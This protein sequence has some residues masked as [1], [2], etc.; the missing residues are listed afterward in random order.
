MLRTSDHHQKIMGWG[1][2][3][4]LYVTERGGGAW[5]NQGNDTL[6]GGGEGVAQAHLFGGPGDDTFFIDS[7]DGT[8]PFGDHVFGGLGA[9][10]F[11]FTGIIP[12]TARITGR[13]DDFDPTRDQ[14]WID[15]DLIDLSNPPDHVRI[16]LWLDQPWI[17]IDGRIL[18]ALEGARQLQDSDD[19]E[20]EEI[21]F[22][23]WPEEWEDGVPKSLDI[24]YTDFVSYFPANLIDQPDSHFNKVEGT[25]RADELIG[26]P[27]DDW[28]HG[29]DGADMILGG[30]GNDI[31]DGGERNDTIYGGPGDDSISGGLDND[32]LYG[33]QGNDYIFGG[34]GDD[35][36][37]GE[38]GDDTLYGNH[39]DDS[40]YGGAGTDLIFGGA[41]KDLLYGGPDD[42][43]LYG[44]ADDDT[45]FGGAGDDTLYGDGGKNYLYGGEGNDQI[46]AT[47]GDTVS[48]GPGKNI[49]SVNIEDGGAIFIEELSDESTID[50]SYQFD[51]SD[52]DIK[53][54]IEETE[55]I[56]RDGV[57]EDGLT[58]FLEGLEEAAIILSEAAA[59]N[60]QG[61][62]S[63]M[64]YP[65][66]AS[67]NDAS[68]ELG[69]SSWDHG[70]WKFSDKDPFSPKIPTKPG[71]KPSDDSEDDDL[72]LD[73]EE[74]QAASDA[75][76][77]V[78][79]AAYGDPMHPDVVSLRAFRDNHLKRYLAGRAFI[80]IYWVVGPALARYT[81]PGGRS[82]YMARGFLRVL[83]SALR[84]NGLCERSQST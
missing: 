27:D 73:E 62:K 11:R 43:I 19:D 9:D 60:F 25:A 31:L 50:L 1:G 14:I 30:D 39:G 13:I 26:T 2:D 35:T 21:H 44:G 83:I 3:D 63:L 40:I 75:T 51:E 7:T 10:E 29:D 82:G 52:T 23:T 66:R 24:P 71:D 8:A 69:Q 22:I 80:K 5:G 54:S 78:A 65:P 32:E 81:F 17:L 42:D 74:I 61:L 68:G 59:N 4:T 36:I 70:A 58:I 53:I 57:R 47:E 72:P 12:G 18:Y 84:T 16:I 33:G 37:Y 56:R 76:C 28:L 48:S 55:I 77:F 34:S 46:Y 20:E 41:G 49:V 6:Y 45:I 79:T 38:Q 64:G 67:L 15:E